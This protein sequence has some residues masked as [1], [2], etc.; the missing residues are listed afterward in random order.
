MSRKLVIRI[1]LSIGLLILI[2][3]FFT[4]QPEVEP[5]HLEGKTMGSIVYNVKYTDEDN[6]NY[7]TEVD[8]I[9][10]SLN[11]SLSTYI[12]DSEISR[13]NQLQE[14]QNPSDMFKVV[15]KKSEEIWI[16]TYG[17]FDPTIGPL[18][19][20]W[21]FGPNGKPNFLDSV[22]VDSLIQYVGFG[23]LLFSQEKIAIEPGMYL[24]FS[25]IAKGYAVDLVAEFLE[26]K[27]VK[28]YMVE[29]GGEVRVKGNN[30]K[31]DPW[32]IGIEDPLVSRLERK[33]LA[34]T[35]LSDISMATSG[36]YRNYYEVDGK[37]IAHTIDPRT[38]FNAQNNVLSASVFARECVTADAYAT[39][40]MVLGLDAS[41]ALLSENNID[42][43][44]VYSEDEEIG[45]YVSENISSVV[46]FVGDINQSTIQ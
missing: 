39:A 24:D 45:A 4:S 7:K 37:T 20:A 42:A 32:K 16:A 11:N 36:N 19:N 25:A 27:K 17:A 14:I 6:T 2:F 35:E 21:G 18:V 15:M 31:G 9:L 38:G 26:K 43:I 46:N 1:I 33:L 10:I 40:I 23:K 41:K 44:I 8:S 29:I 30:E 28:N 34:I 22:V 12:N 3:Q 5:V 13:L